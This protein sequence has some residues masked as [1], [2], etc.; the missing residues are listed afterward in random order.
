LQT[1]RTRPVASTSKSF[2]DPFLLLA[3]TLFGLA[4][5][6]FAIAAVSEVDG[7]TAALTKMRS[8]LGSK[9]LSARRVD[10]DG[11]SSRTPGG[12]RYRD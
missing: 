8:R 10:L 7:G 11:A 12:I 5:L 9:G 3:V 6:A 1:P 4:V 2:D